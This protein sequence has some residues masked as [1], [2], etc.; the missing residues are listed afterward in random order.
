MILQ[1]DPQVRGPLSRTGFQKLEAEPSSREVKRALGDKIPAPSHL[2][3]GSCLFT[4]EST[5]VDQV[6]ENSN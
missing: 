2:P 3:Q 1:E 4:K 6:S 5:M